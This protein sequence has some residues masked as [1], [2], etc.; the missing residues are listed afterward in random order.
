M[1][2]NIT[3]NRTVPPLKTFVEQGGTIVALGSS[4]AIGAAMGLPVKN[5]LVEANGDPLPRTKYYIPGGILRASIDNTNPI[6][7]GMPKDGMIFFDNSPVFSPITDTSVKVNTVISF[8]EKAPLYSGW[9][10]G[11]EYLQ[12]GSVANEASIGSGKLV[13]LGLEATFRATTLFFNSLYYGSAA[14]AN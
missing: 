9:G 1:L 3:Q 10:H 14:P 11:Q 4:A 5:H 12:G 7:Y 13:L 2:G 6:A 8:T